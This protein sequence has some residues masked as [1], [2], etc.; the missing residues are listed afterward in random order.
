MLD[1][2]L[3]IAVRAANPCLILKGQEVYFGKLL[4]F[5]PEI[6]YLHIFD[7]GYVIESINFCGL[8]G[9]PMPPDLKVVVYW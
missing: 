5:I 4:M 6:K 2:N 3:N 8:V 7:G 9:V 1:Q